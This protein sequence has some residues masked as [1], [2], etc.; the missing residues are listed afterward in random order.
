[1][2]YLA[3]VKGLLKSDYTRA[4]MEGWAREHKHLASLPNNNSLP[5]RR[6]T[7]VS[8]NAA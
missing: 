7:T 3:V 2:L 8:I 5:A 1:L 6:K 4:V